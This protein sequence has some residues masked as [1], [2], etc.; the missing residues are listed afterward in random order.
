[1]KLRCDVRMGPISQRGARFAR[2]VGR[3]LFRAAD[4]RRRATRPTMTAPLAP[5]KAIAREIGT[6]DTGA[7]T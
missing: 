5:T 7:V 6:D 1:M 3:I 4:V 2:R